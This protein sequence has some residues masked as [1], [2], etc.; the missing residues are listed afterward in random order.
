MLTTANEWQHMVKVPIV[1]INHRA[2][3]MTSPAAPLEHN[4]PMHPLNK[5]GAL[6]CL[7]LPSVGMNNIRVF[8]AILSVRLCLDPRPKPALPSCIDAGLG[9]DDIG[10]IPLPHRYRLVLAVTTKTT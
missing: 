4:R 6:D 9:A 8:F 5:R 10:I 1:G 3:H 2:A 7:A